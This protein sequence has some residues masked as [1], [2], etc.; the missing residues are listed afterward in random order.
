MYFKM[1]HPQGCRKQTGQ[2]PKRAEKICYDNDIIISY[3]KCTSLVYYSYQCHYI[4]DIL[5]LKWYI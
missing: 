2:K 1:I 5:M 3:N 4:N